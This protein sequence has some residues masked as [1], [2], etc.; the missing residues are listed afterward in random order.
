[1]PRKIRIGHPRQF[2]ISGDSTDF[3]L[4]G[5]AASLNRGRSM[6]GAFGIYTQSGQDVTFSIGTGGGEVTNPIDAVRRVD[7]ST[8]GVEGGIPTRTTV[9]STVAPYTGSAAALNTAIT[10]ASN[11]GGNNVVQL[12]AGTY[13]LSSTLQMKS[14]V[15]LRGVGMSTIIRFT[16]TGGSNFF[17]GG[18]NICVIFQGAFDSSGY[19]GSAGTPQQGGVPAAKRRSWTGTGGS[20]GVYSKDATVLNLASAPTGLAVG[21]ML[22]LYQTDEAA[23]SLPKNGF[24][25][26]DKTGTNAITWQGS[27]GSPTCMQQRVR[28]V[29]ISGNDVTIWPGIFHPTGAWKTANTPMVGWQGNDIRNAGIEDCLIDGNTSGPAN[30]WSCVQF[31]QASNCWLYRCGV[32][33]KT[34]AFRAGNTTQMSVQMFE[35]R[36]ITVKSCWID[37]AVGGGQGSTTTY[38]I[39]S[40]LG[41][42]CLV[43]NNIFYQNESPQL[44][45]NGAIGCV[46]AYNHEILDPQHEGGTQFHETG[47]AYNLIEGCNTT[48][49]WGDLFHGPA[50][51]CT[52]FRNYVQSTSTSN[53][54]GISLE[55]YHRYQNLV[56]NVIAAPAGYT[57]LNTDATKYSRFEGWA[58]RFGYPNEDASNTTTTGVAGD[59]QVVAT[60]MRWGNYTAFD[61]QTRFLASEIPSAEAFFPNAVPGSNTLPSSMYLSSRPSFFTHNGVTLTWPPIGS[62]VT[63]G[64]AQAGHVYKIPS[65]VEYERATTVTSFN[66][67][68][69]G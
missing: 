44:F 54:A 1:M 68:L 56:G 51:F 48:K 19:S 32:K 42:H 14:N 39:I 52:V 34:G 24:F 27:N 37:R 65:Q 4:T 59:P 67:T 50:N 45:H 36:N 49:V 15:T 6:D 33:P 16:N 2:R 31:W 18:G 60:T 5:V 8:A 69:Y 57:T 46:Y 35:S 10:N 23:A 53:G 26:S 28:V 38:G 58:F 11:A 61:G 30:Q 47:V 66:P 62:D 9:H 22:T 40:V 43:E 41:S 55:S 21:D 29:S 25:V 64:V 20:S 3:T 17:F 7:W 12:Q 13:L 63:G